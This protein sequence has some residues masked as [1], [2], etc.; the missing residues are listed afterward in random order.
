MSGYSE[1]VLAR[2]DQAL[3]DVADQLRRADTKAAS[4]LPLFGGFLAGVV[5]LTTRDLPVVA[6][7]IMWLAAAP[8]MVSVLL[9]LSAVRPRN[10]KG[11]RHGFAHFA[12]Y[13]ERPS[14]LLE[15]FESEAPATA[16]AVDVCRL[17]L[18][19]RAKYAD[20]RRAIDLLMVGLVL[21]G[22]ALVVTAAL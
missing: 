17:S 13:V 16:L 9:L 19:V 21:L 5:A 18:I 10:S 15:Q 6:E 14:E 22:V 1:H 11:A 12:R 20:V 3:A 8:M 2:V 4:M 7:V